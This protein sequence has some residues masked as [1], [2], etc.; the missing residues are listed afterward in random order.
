MRVFKLIP[1]TALLT[2]MNKGKKNKIPM[3]QIKKKVRILVIFFDD[4]KNKTTKIIDADVNEN[5]VLI[6]ATSPRKK[7]TQ[8]KTKS[9]V[10]LKS[11]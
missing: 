6:E 7:D 2:L 11:L 1:L 8:S 3:R 4:L 9:D 10:F 5:Q